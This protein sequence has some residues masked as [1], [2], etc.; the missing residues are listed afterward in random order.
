ML[1]DN[2]E[3]VIINDKEVK[4]IKTNEGVI[5]E[6]PSL[7]LAGDK[8]II[9]KDE[10]LT[11]TATYTDYKGNGISGKTVTFYVEESS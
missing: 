4:S 5:Y 1:F 3:Q 11:L 2:A 6:R 10:T 8:E 9:Q 7:T